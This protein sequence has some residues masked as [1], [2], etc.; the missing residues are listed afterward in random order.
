MK[1]QEQVMP[2]PQRPITHITSTYLQQIQ[3]SLGG[4]CFDLMCIC[5]QSPQSYARNIYENASMRN[6]NV[7][8]QS[9]QRLGLQK[10][11]E[12]ILPTYSE[13]RNG[14]LDDGL[15]PPWGVI[16][17]CTRLRL[18]RSS[19]DSPKIL[20]KS[21]RDLFFFFFFFFLRF[22]AQVRW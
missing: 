21:R 17:R 5:K 19:D 16:A 15:M 4:L 8:E 6:Q 3:R 2:A 9:R 22:E 13:T 7:P 1:L 10:R 11:S 14:T 18:T 20:N 12:F